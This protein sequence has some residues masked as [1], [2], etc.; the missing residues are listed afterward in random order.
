[1]A[2]SERLM[3]NAAG[4]FVFEGYLIPKH[5]IVRV[6]LWESHKSGESFPDPFRFDPARFMERDP[7]GDE[8]SPFGLDHHHCPLADLTVELSK[9][10]LRALARGYTIG[11]VEDG[12]PVRGTYHWQPATHFSVELHGRSA[13]A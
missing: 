9:V 4:T 10:F 6:C 5:A 12:M 3:R 7:S 13:R 8:F 2:Q 1:M 11:A